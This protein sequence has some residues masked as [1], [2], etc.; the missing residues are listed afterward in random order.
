MI[1]KHLPTIA[2]LFHFVSVC[3]AAQFTIQIYDKHSN[4]HQY[5]VKIKTTRYTFADLKKALK[6]QLSSQA[7][8]DQI[9]LLVFCSDAQST[10]LDDSKEIEQ[11]KR[12]I[13]SGYPIEIVNRFDGKTL[14]AYR[15]PVDTCGQI[16]KRTKGEHHNLLVEDIQS[17]NEHL[18]QTVNRIYVFPNDHIKFTQQSLRPGEQILKGFAKR[19]EHAIRQA[20]YNQSQRASKKTNHGWLFPFKQPQDIAICDNLA[21][22]E[23]QVKLSDQYVTVVDRNGIKMV[24]VCPDDTFRT[25][26]E[27]LYESECANY[28]AEVEDATQIIGDDY[29]SSRYEKKDKEIFVVAYQDNKPIDYVYEFKVHKGDKI[30]YKMAGV[31]PCYLQTHSQKRVPLTAKLLQRLIVEHNRM[32][33]LPKSIVAV[34]ICIDQKPLEAGR[35]ICD[36]I[37][38]R[39]IYTKVNVTDSQQGLRFVHMCPEPTIRHVAEQI[40]NVFGTDGQVQFVNGRGEHMTFENPDAHFKELDKAWF[41]NI[42]CKFVPSTN[43]GEKSKDGQLIPE[44]L[45]TNKATVTEPSNVLFD[46]SSAMPESTLS[47]REDVKDLGTSELT[48]ESNLESNLEPPTTVN[49]MTSNVSLTT[50]KFIKSSRRVSR[51]LLVI[52]FCL[53]IFVTVY[54]LHASYV[55]TSSIVSYL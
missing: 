25:L 38:D 54:L 39:D 37:I 23:P 51:Y 27:R 4:P 6:R 11:S 2:C 13:I 45:V 52:A 20:V 48:L 30:T 5:K 53:F 55:L 28:R 42:R 40:K 7:D 12:V 31:A 16:L 9:D 33:G 1:S 14:V 21:H 8:K 19:S 41:T 34:P 22:S 29:K 43:V 36:S 47:S 24:T 44:P 10:P 26:L 32:R 50:T 17:L 3:F 46:Q 35:H 15:C 18:P 49:D